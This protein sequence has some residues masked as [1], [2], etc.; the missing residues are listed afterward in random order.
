MG[1]QVLLKGLVLD[2][3][4]FA[5]RKEIKMDTY[6]GLELGKKGDL[7]EFRPTVLFLVEGN[8]IFKCKGMRKKLDE[9]NKS[10]RKTALDITDK[11]EHKSKEAVSGV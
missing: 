8:I 7:S 1:T 10:L 2:I 3:S 5:R 9:R 6:I 11:S 4:L